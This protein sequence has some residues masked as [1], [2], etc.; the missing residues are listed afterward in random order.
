MHTHR[1]QTLPAPGVIWSV[2][3]MQACVV[4][5]MA[6]AVG[7]VHSSVLHVHASACA[8]QRVHSMLHS[9]LLWQG[10]WRLPQLGNDTDYNCQLAAA[11]LQLGDSKQQGWARLAQA[12]SHGL[13]APM[14][15]AAAAAAGLAS[16]RC[17]S[18]LQLVIGIARRPS[19]RVCINY[20]TAC[21]NNS[22]WQAWAWCSSCNASNEVLQAGNS[23]NLP[24]PFRQSDYAATP[25][26]H[27]TC[28]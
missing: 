11:V 25:P 6:A 17:A 23:R 4:L 20:W 26:E 3:I 18:M 9:S 21:S 10:W 16:S 24:L 13:A 7:L 12:L 8:V 15:P 19:C 14:A 5:S 28:C 22:P 27:A 1:R 2:F